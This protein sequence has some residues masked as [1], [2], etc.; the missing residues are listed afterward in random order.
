[1]FKVKEKT[2]KNAEPKGEKMKTK[3]VT[4]Q[5]ARL[6][7]CQNF[8]F[9]FFILSNNL[10]SK[11]PKCHTKLV[12]W[13]CLTAETSPRGLHQQNGLTILMWSS[14]IYKYFKHYLALIQARLGQTRRGAERCA[15]DR[16]GWGP[17]AKPG[18]GAQHCGHGSE[19]CQNKV[20]LI[21]S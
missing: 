3:V 17:A 18:Q 5:K 1:M 10:R 8:I 12:L 11:K 16:Q 14:I 9:I 20:L 6:Y 2:K 4:R 7:Y 21:L 15:Q 19:N 13:K